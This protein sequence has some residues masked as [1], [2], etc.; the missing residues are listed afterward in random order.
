VI[1]IGNPVAIFFQLFA[2]YIKQEAYK[3]PASHASRSPTISPKKSGVGLGHIISPVRAP[4]LTRA[5]YSS[6][7]KQLPKADHG[8]K[9]Y[10]S[11]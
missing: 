5:Y 10:S 1:A 11:Q 6:K 3:T 4:K 8:P 2:G 9:A 7:Y